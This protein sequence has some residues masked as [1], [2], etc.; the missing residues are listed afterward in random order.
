MDNPETETTLETRQRTQTKRQKQ[1]TKSN[2][3]PIKQ[4]H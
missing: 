3:D 2:T 1:L 4:S